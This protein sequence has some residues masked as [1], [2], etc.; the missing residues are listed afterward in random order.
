[1]LKVSTAS[2]WLAYG[3]FFMVVLE[4]VMLIGTIYIN[5]IGGDV[6][7]IL[8]VNFWMFIIVSSLGFI[9]ILMIIILSFFEVAFID[10]RNKKE[11]FNV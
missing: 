11:D 10:E 6:S 9:W 5:Q 4:I 1:M 3:A 8:R 2:F 7:S